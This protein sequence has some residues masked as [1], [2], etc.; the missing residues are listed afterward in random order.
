MGV[1]RGGVKER[2]Q[3]GVGRGVGITIEIHDVRIHS[4]NEKK[5]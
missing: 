4:D 1:G 3:Q 5:I 2:R